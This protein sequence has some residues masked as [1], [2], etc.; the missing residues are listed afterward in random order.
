MIIT[1]D[2]CLTKFNLDDSKIPAKGT[3]VRCSRCQHV[4]FIVPPQEAKEEVDENF[5]SFAKY[6]REELIGPEEKGGGDQKFE[7]LLKPQKES[8]RPVEKEREFPE[9]TAPI[10]FEKEPRPVEEKEEEAFLFSEKAPPEKGVKVIPSEEREPEEKVSKPKK[11]IVEKEKRGFPLSL[12]IVVVLILLVLGAFY[13][14]WTKGGSVGQVST[15]LE[16][17]I[18]KINSLWKQVLGTEKRGLTIG[19]YTGYTEE[20]GGFSLYI[21]EGKVNNQSGS[22]KRHIKLKVAIFDQNKVKVAEKETLCGSIIDREELRTLPASFFEGEIIIR[23]KKEEEM[24]VPSGKTIPFMV[25]FKHLSDQAKEF[26]VEIVEAP[27]L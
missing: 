20:I 11:M 13:F 12:A 15:Y 2:S 4:F 25:I 5:E 7:S 19:D 18:G 1:C 17:P 27:N 21:I 14:F 16:Y 6:Y 23:P 26:T 10:E 24:I 8:P 3:K 9:F 22:T